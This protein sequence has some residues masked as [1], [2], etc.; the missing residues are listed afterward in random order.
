MQLD[1][2]NE[3]SL[4]YQEIAHPLFVTQEGFLESRLHVLEKPQDVDS[5]KVI[6]CDEDDAFIAQLTLLLGIVTVRVA[7]QHVKL[8]ENVFV[9]PEVCSV[10]RE[11]VKVRDM[12]QEP[13][14]AMSVVEIVKVTRPVVAIDVVNVGAV[15][16]VEQ[17]IAADKPK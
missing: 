12:V 6:V 5:E 1:N 8:K 16:H 3:V 15:E 4:V 9:Y 7:E 11:S 2:D 14:L 13:Q 10:F 17:E